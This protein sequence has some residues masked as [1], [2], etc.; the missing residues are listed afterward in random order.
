[1]SELADH[2]QPA[3]TDAAYAAK[4]RDGIMVGIAP[5][6]EVMLDDDL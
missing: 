1:M 6:V 4:N 5:V 3:S 2:N